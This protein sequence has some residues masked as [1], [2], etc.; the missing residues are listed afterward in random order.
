MDSK[1]VNYLIKTPAGSVYHSGDSH[2]SIYFAK[3]GKDYDIDVAFGSFG[4]NPVGNQ[5]K[6]T[7]SDM[8]RMAEA[9][10]CKVLIPFH[11]DLWTNFMADPVEI[12]MLYEFKKHTLDY[13]FSTFIWEVGGMYTY[14]TDKNKRRY[15][16][17]RGFEDCFT[18]EQ[19]IPF[20]ALL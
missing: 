13:K 8:L 5:D 10:N 12:E 19:N 4:E 6:M 16:Y 15:H 11:Y 17:R 3:H 20:K 1:A 7:S 9:L 18:E 2:H 14:P